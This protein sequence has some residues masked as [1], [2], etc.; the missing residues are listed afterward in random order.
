MPQC[1]LHHVR[2]AGMAS[3]VPK[4]RVSNLT[5]CPPAMRGERERLVRNIGIEYR[6]VAQPWARAAWPWPAAQWA[7]AAS[8]CW[9]RR[10]LRNWRT[11]AFMTRYCPKA[12]GFTAIENP[13]IPPWRME[14]GQACL[15]RG[16]HVF[17][18]VS[19]RSP[20]C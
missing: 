9:G 3:C 1:I 4:G 14:A 13:F 6:R 18:P 11:T 16:S 8:G 2:F 12:P 15:C 19:P 10:C 17:F 5:D 20:L 7:S